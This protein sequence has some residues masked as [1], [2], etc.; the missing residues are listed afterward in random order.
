M[1]RNEKYVDKDGNVKEAIS[2]GTKY[3]E[4]IIWYDFEEIKNFFK[5]WTVPKT[6]QMGKYKDMECICSPRIS[7]TEE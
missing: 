3:T 4:L 5:N 6:L 7:K 1:A 2:Y